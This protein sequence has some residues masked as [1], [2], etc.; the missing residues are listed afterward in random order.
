MINR[1]GHKRKETLNIESS[2]LPL[3]S[4]ILSPRQVTCFH[5]NNLRSLKAKV[6]FDRTAVGDNLNA[7]RLRS[8]ALF[9][10]SGVISPLASEP[11]RCFLSFNFSRHF[12]WNIF[13]CCK[14]L[15]PNYWI[16]SKLPAWL[17][18]ASETGGEKVCCYL[19]FIIGWTDPLRL[20]WSYSN[21]ACFVL[22]LI[23]GAVA[24]ASCASALL[25][26]GVPRAWLHFCHFSF[27]P[28]TETTRFSVISSSLHKLALQTFQRLD[29]IHVAGTLSSWVGFRLTFHCQCYSWWGKVVSHK[30]W[31][32]WQNG[33]KTTRKRGWEWHER[34]GNDLHLGDG[35]ERWFSC[36]RIWITV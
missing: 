11:P 1:R 19:Y 2:P 23:Y 30:P 31:R 22:L 5:R 34:L 9:Q 24:F 33:M 12:L 26:P 10:D 14:C 25:R 21:Y 27:F 15:E 17:D 29:F 8:A 35:G 6:L 20:W 3:N 32:F 28:Q 36:G 13:H 7:L 16:K 4:R 18:T